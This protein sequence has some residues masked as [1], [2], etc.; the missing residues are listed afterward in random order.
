M[1]AAA[2]AAISF[3][4]ILAA[5]STA[6]AE[7]RLTIHDGRVS[8]VARDA[9]AGEILSEW[10]RVGQTKVVNLDRAPRDRMTIEL[11]NVSE[12]EALSLVLRSASGYVAASRAAALEGGSIFDRILLMPPSV[13]PVAVKATAPSA[14][15]RPVPAADEAQAYAAPPAPPAPPQVADD[16][17]SE[18]T[19]MGG[20][21]IV[22]SEAGAVAPPPP[23][24]QSA[25]RGRR[26]LETM[27]PREFRIPVQPQGSVVVPHDP[28]QPAAQQRPGM[29]VQPR[30]VRN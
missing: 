20:E 5:G 6:G 11:S 22:V 8:M 1:R 23:S 15:L 21:D 16:A 4:L 17:G 12:E 10:G 27:D 9:T 19:A 3:C 26:A 29:P 28:A 13:A 2:L 18:A 30:S 7:V 24:V 25:Y 14:A